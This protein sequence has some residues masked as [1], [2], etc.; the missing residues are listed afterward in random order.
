MKIIL[1][2]VGVILALIVVFAITPVILTGVDIPYQT[3]NITYYY[4]LSDLNDIAPLII[5]AGFLIVAMGGVGWAF[6]GKIIDHLGG[7]GW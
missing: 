1:A 3:H 2:I 7:G 5:Y 6:R 4:G